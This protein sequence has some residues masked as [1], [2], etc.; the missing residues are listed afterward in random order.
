MMVNLANVIQTMPNS[1]EK[2]LVRGWKVLVGVASKHSN[3]RPSLKYQISY[4]SWPYGA[5]MGQEKSCYYESDHA[6]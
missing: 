6:Q 1:Q 5:I 2:R 4:N 3:T